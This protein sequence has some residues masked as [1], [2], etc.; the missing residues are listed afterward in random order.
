MLASALKARR[1][2]GG[3]ALCAMGCASAGTDAP[4]APEVVKAWDPRP[5]VTYILKNQ[6]ADGTWDC[7]H[8]VNPDTGGGVT[9]GTAA[10]AC[11]ALLER[12]DLAPA[13]VD[14]AVRKGIAAC[15]SRVW[16]KDAAAYDFEAIAWGQLYTLLLLS[17]ASTLETFQKEAIPWRG[18]QED[19]LKFLLLRRTPEGGWGYR[20]SF[21]TAATL[22]GL[23]ELKAAGLAVPDEALERAGACMGKF[24]VGHSYRYSLGVKRKQ[25][26]AKEE[27][28]RTE[29]SAGRLGVCALA[30][31]AMGKIPAKEFEGDVEAFMA[32]RDFLWKT[33]ADTMEGIFTRDGGCSPYM[34][35]AFFGYRYAAE[36]VAHV[37]DSEKRRAWAKTLR[38]D[39][40]REVETDGGWLNIP[41]EYSDAPPGFYSN[42]DPGRRIYAS[43]MGLMALK[44]LERASA[45]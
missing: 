20:A 23:L 27:P 8:Q 38:E 45:P 41:K 34:F 44:S 26:E 37:A 22:L 3:L 9:V 2:L 30:L 13:E 11:M 39:L 17:R 4:S 6:K 5:T 36:A 19:I 25:Q 14:E 33:R 12:R 35:F 29:D 21:Q 28:R 15:L 40:L 10:L 43:A 42:T 1:W 32:H 7:G 16:R 31:Q 24:R 18:E